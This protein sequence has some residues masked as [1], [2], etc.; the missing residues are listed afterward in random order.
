MKTI[1]QITL[2]LVALLLSSSPIYAHDFEVDGIYYNIQS[3]SDKTVEVTYKGSYYA[4]YTEYSGNVTI[5]STVTNSGTTYSITSIGEYAFSECS[6]LTSVTI[7]NSV[8]SIGKSAFS[9]CSGLTSVTIGNSVA[10]IGSHAFYEC[11]GLT[12]VT[13]GNSVTSIGKYAFSGCSSLTSVT[14]PNSV[15]SIGYSAFYGCKNL[16]QVTN[17]SKLSL[18]KGSNNH[19]Y[20]AYYATIIINK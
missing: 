9:R 2:L 16:N 20:V 19:G 10:S 3:K 4:T 13:I 5:P 17:L 15:T 18:S 8:T 11:S 7:G 1:L 14:I 12:S 6:G